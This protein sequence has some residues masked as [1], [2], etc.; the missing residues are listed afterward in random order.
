M[1]LQQGEKQFWKF[2]ISSKKIVFCFLSLNFPTVLRKKI[3]NLIYSQKI[4]SILEM[5]PN[6]RN[7]VQRNNLVNSGKIFRIRC[8]IKISKKNITLGNFFKILKKLV[9]KHRGS[10]FFCND[11]T[12]TMEIIETR[13]DSNFC[14]T[15]FFHFN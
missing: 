12:K 5:F 1:R 6:L 10:S 8:K 7:I 4:H 2:F 3:Q 14:K 13:W 15:K 9:T 11:K